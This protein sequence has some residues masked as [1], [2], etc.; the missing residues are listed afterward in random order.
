M[1]TPQTKT[2]SK[3]TKTNFGMS[4]SDTTTAK[5]PF[6]ACKL[7]D[8]GGDV[9]KQWVVEYYVYN[10]DQDKLVRRRVSGF[11]RIKTV[12]ARKAA[13]RELMQ[14]IDELLR[15]GYTEGGKE[16]L[17]DSL[18]FLQES[19]ADFNLSTFTLRQAVFLIKLQ[20]PSLQLSVL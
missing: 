18:A 5:Y 16:T 9:S 17:S 10:R 12:R 19:E 4:K 1:F 6:H 20:T 13:A 3:T 2:K 7:Y 15:Q 8:S 14:Q 11:N